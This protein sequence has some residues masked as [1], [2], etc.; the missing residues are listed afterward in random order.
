MRGAGRA[1]SM[2]GR[3]A[4]NQEDTALLI[5]MVRG[6]SD[7]C[8]L[9]SLSRRRLDAERTR[10]QL[11]AWRAQRMLHDVH[12]D[13]AAPQRLAMILQVGGIRFKWEP[14]ACIAICFR[15]ARHRRGWR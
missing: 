3:R 10:V 9:G 7:T 12:R 15:P 13:A 4:G 11:G 6:S 2:R 1:H 5:M 8:L 14:S